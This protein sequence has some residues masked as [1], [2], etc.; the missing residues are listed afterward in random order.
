MAR[1]LNGAFARRR[2]ATSSDAELLEK[3]F[4]ASGAAFDVLMAR[5]GTMV[6][7]VCR[8]DPPR[9]ARG[10][11]RLPGRLSCGTGAAGG[12]AM[13]RRESFGT[14]GCTGWP[15]RRWPCGRGRRPRCAGSREARAAIDPAAAVTKVRGDHELGPACTPRS[16]ACR[17]VPLADRPLLPPG[18]DDRRGLRSA[19]LAGRHRGPALARA[20]DRL[21]QIGSSS[22]GWCSAAL[23]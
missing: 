18:A 10:R 19:R 17:E 2:W 13:R 1:P 15:G 5:H 8:R 4:P 22:K 6:L 9:R 7:A 16:I 11:R 12:W 20:R 3:R 14:M 21:R 23:L